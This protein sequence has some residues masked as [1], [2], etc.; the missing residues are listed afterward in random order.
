MVDLRKL[1]LAE[2]RALRNKLEQREKKLETGRVG[3][4]RAKVMT[5]LR[6]EG[7]TLQDLVKDSSGGGAPSGGKRRGRK[8]KAAGASS[9][10][11]G[12]KV[13]P[14]YR[15]PNDAN[16][17]WTGRGVSPKWFAALIE[18]GMTRDQLL[19]K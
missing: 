10:L 8:P 12:K 15:S 11:S 1:N 3:L 6:K 13:A 9:K 17:T 14:K 7:L 18:Q 4:L 19:I 5:M 2:V 16:L